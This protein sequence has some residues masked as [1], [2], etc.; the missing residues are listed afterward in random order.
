M[1]I[2]GQHKYLTLDNSCKSKLSS[3]SP[4]KTI[5]NRAESQILGFIETGISNRL[6]EIKYDGN[7]V[8]SLSIFFGRIP[9]NSN[10]LL[11]LNEFNLWEFKDSDGQFGRFKLSIRFFKPVENDRYEEFMTY[12]SIHSVHGQID[13]TNKLIFA[14]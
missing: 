6:T 12:D 11:M 1:S 7:L 5:D 3:V 9:G 2:F 13:V 4:I 14:K 10:I 8:D